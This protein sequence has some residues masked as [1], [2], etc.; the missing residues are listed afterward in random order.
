M[1]DVA[2]SARDGSGEAIT[3]A[4][5]LAL[6]Q[7]SPRTRRELWLRFDEA[8]WELYSYDVHGCAEIVCGGGLSDDWFVYW[9][10][11]IVLQGG[12]LH[13]AMR[14]NPDAALA[15]YWESVGLTGLDT[16][17]V[18]DF[19]YAEQALYAFAD[20]AGGHC[21]SSPRLRSLMRGKPRG[22]P[23]SSE[24]E[25]RRRFPALLRLFASR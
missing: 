18:N 5:R 15:D 9:R 6:P 16:K 8:T 4:L 25:W 23:W 7:L 20:S 11:W 24:V 2:A 3:Q 12:S 10:R 19:C 14:R 1:D 21:P 13:R 22:R 17:D